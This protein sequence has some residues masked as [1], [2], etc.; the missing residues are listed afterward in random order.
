[1][2]GNP[3]AQAL[4]TTQAGLLLGTRAGLFRWQGDTHRWE[5]MPGDF[6]PGGINSLTADPTQPQV[7]Y[8]GT[9]GDG[10]YRSDDG[11]DSWRQVPSLGMGIP[12]V[13]V[14]PKDSQRLYILAAWERVY[15]SRDGGQS[16]NA[17][18][19]GLGDVV[20]TASIAVDPLKSNVYVGTESGLYRSHDGGF[21][22]FMAT[23]LAHQSILALLTQSAPPSSGGGTILYLGTTQGIYR[24]M[25]SGATVQGGGKEQWG[26]RA[27][28]QEWESDVWGQGLEDVSVTALLADPHDPNR[29][30]AGTAYAGVYQSIDWGHTWQPIGPAELGEDTVK[31]LAWGPEGA[32]FVA[33]TGGVWMGVRQ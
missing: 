23:T 19:K 4:L 11:G 1:M 8:A 27:A 9:N 10:L 2:L 24:S 7:F 31:G 14:D 20:E 29:L 16:W 13:A 22:K 17:R 32:L 12:A 3:N 33:T 18:W 6:P 26:R 5:V 15:E 28:G 25:D 21:W 30:Y